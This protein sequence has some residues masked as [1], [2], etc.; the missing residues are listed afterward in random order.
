MHSGFTVVGVVQEALH[1]LLQLL[2]AVEEVVGVVRVHPA[3]DAEQLQVH[4][5]EVLL[6]LLPVLLEVRGAR[7]LYLEEDLL[8]HGPLRG[9]LLLHEQAVQRPEGLSAEVHL[10]Q[11]L[12]DLRAQLVREAP[13]E[14]EELRGEV[15]DLELHLRVLGVEALREE[16]LAEQVIQEG[17][18]QGHEGLG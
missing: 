8:G 17:Y 13:V 10:P 16:A 5:Q 11:P 1:E 12:G 7:E 4:Q 6:A 3:G 9:D 15:R 2:E 18:V 14:H